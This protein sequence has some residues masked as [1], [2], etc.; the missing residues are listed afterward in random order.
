V[1]P[2]EREDA[3]RFLRDIEDEPVAL[4]R[5]SDTYFGGASP[6]RSVRESSAIT[7]A[8]LVLTGMGSSYYAALVGAWWLQRYGI[9]GWATY[10]SELDEFPP[11]GRWA[12]VAVSQSGA[13]AETLRAVEAFRRSCDGPVI[14]V[15]NRGDSPLAG[16]GDIVLPLL[17]GAEGR[18]PGKSWVASVAVMMLVAQ[19]LTGDVHLLERSTMETAVRTL[20]RILASY[21][22]IGAS[23]AESLAG[24]R[25]L[26]VL[27]SGPGLASAYECATVMKETAR[28]P[29]EPMLAA[30]FLHG[31][32]LLVQPGYA[33]V[34][35]SGSLTG[36]RDRDV[37]DLI[38]KRG[39]RVVDLG[40]QA[41]RPMAELLATLPP[42]A[43]PLVEA[44]PIEQFAASAWLARLDGEA[45]ER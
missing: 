31:A 30:D 7:G 25:V 12:L 9:A 2:S 38:I 20:E 43:R 16:A 41:P 4:Q 24:A 6:L 37:R 36:S 19:A 1:A 45:H 33:A 18:V 8:R 40:E 27:G 26:H 39:G 14:A 34:L 29:A 44:C 23:I 35:F 15:V 28:L 11:G 42:G 13:T 32:Y 17:A 3:V 22:E 5:V 21:D 10:A